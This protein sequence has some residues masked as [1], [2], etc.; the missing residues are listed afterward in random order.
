MAISTES[1]LPFLKN[2]SGSAPSST[3]K[4]SAGCSNLSSSVMETVAVASFAAKGI[5][6]VSGPEKSSAPAVPGV[7]ISPIS[8]P[9]D[10]RTGEV[11]LI[12]RVTSSPSFAVVES[13]DNV[14]TPRMS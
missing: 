2:A 1:F 3:V 13:A 9:C 7:Y 10:S 5:L 6:T 4:V 12:V 11:R 14:T 8:D